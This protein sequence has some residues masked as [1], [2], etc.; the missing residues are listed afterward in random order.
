M[1]AQARRCF[2]SAQTVELVLKLVAFGANKATVALDV[3]GPASPR[4]LSSLRYDDGV[5]VVSP[6]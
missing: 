1:E 6:A 2:S 3:D 4:G 5:A